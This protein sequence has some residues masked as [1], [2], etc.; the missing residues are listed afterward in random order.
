MFIG[1]DIGGTNIKGVLTEKSGKILSFKSIPTEDKAENIE[2]SIYGIIETL[3]TSASVSKIDIKAMGVGAAG[4]I[5]RKKGTVILSPNVKA[6]N[7]YPLVKRFEKVTGLR[8]FLENDATAALVGTWWQGPGKKY[9]NWLL[10][11]LGTGIGGGVVIDNNLYT[12]RSGSSME[13]GH[14]TIS[15]DGKECSCGNR[16]CLERYASATAL[17]EY[18]KEHAK[19]H[20]DTTLKQHL[21]DDTLTAEI[22]YEQA[23][24]GDDLAKNAINEIA[25]FLGI[26][27]ANLVNIFNPEAVILGGG[28][29]GACKLLIPRIKK[30]VNER[31]LPGMK[32]NIE[33]IALRDQEKFAPLGAA[34]LAIN[35]LNANL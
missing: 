16:G 30:V 34:K 35:S 9:R 7:N 4:S 14:M 6:W 22:V 21:K 19:K 17:M 2:K 18:V 25:T 12:G 3:A 27:M 10:L 23:L 1:I 26:G 32:E 11:T 33:Y 28:L 24:G 8:V 31:A 29:S 13:I 20:K 5:D 15:Y